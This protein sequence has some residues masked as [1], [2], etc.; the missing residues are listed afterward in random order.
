MNQTKTTVSIVDDETDLRESIIRYLDLSGEFHCVS[1]YAR[2]ED[3]LGGLPGERP[4][5]VLMDI[6]M[7][8]MNGIECV[9]RL[10]EKMPLVQIIMLTVFEDSD[11]I[12]AALR[13]GATGYLLKSQ[14]PEKLLE[15]IRDVVAG[16]SPMSA[17]IA[18]K[19]VQLVR[20]TNRPETSGPGGHIELS[21]RQRQVLEL[22]AA[23]QPYKLIADN[24]GVSIH[25]VRSYLRRTY[26]KLQ[27]HSRTEAVAKYKER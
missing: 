23:G 21:E 18:R 22:L 7:E 1:D 17:S 19:V 5:V 20:T 13:A 3:A 6:K 2:A 4:D 16:G 24:L 11:L 12:F 9:G 15:A 25:T 14:P 10:K 8:G 27:V 26:E